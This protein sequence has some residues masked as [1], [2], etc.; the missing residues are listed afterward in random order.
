MIFLEKKKKK[1][2]LAKKKNALTH[3][4]V[5]HSLTVKGSSAVAKKRIERR[6]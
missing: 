1:G 4:I 3:Y 5:L 2:K 6:Q